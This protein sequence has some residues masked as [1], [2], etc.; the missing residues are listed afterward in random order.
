ML[1]RIGAAA[2]CVIIAAAAALSTIHP[3]VGMS[4]ESQHAVHPLDTEI[5]IELGLALERK[6]HL[7]QAEE[8]LIEAA[9]FD[10]QLLPAWTLA[11]FYFRQERTD[12]FW[13]WAARSAAL[14]YDDYRPLLRLA[15]RL[16]QDPGAVVGHLGDRP[17]LLRAYLD[18]LIGERRP[19]DARRVGQMLAAHGNPADRERL[20]AI[21]HLR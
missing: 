6:G 14:T 2:I 4:L 11:N 9:R 5:S 12:D 18:L 10:H 17:P 3:E 15:D 16:E 1:V 13:R 21:S 8:T 7:A 19:Q 20:I